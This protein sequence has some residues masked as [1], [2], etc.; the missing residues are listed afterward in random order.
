MVEAG[1]EVTD[2]TGQAYPAVQ[3]PLQP[4]VDSAGTSPY[5]PAAQSMQVHAPAREY[6]PGAHA[7]WVADT[8]AAGHT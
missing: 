6:F 4:A 8:D 5:S 1:V 2:P 3:F 7:V